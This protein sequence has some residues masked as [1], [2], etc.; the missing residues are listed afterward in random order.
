MRILILEDDGYRV[1]YFIEKFG[2]HDL[3]ITENAEEA[4]NHLERKVF[5]VIFLDNDL[6]EGNGEGRFVSKFLKAHQTNPN[7][8][9]QVVVHSLNIPATEQMLADLPEAIRAP[10]NSRTFLNITLDK[11]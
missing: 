2:Q 6:G 9:A 8:L 4:I 7:N 11:H 1:K 10:F 3:V 5:D